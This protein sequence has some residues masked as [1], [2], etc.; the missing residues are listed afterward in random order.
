[1]NNLSL[2]RR[3]FNDD[4]AEMNRLMNRM[5]GE[6]GGL[7]TAG[8]TELATIDFTPTVDVEENDEGYVIKADLPQIK[9]EDVKINVQ[10]GILTLSGERKQEKEEKGKKFHRVERSYG[11]F[12]RSFQ[13]P[14]N[15]DDT[16]IAATYTDGVLKVLLPKAEQPKPN[17]REI[18]VG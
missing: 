15:V 16:K 2:F 11:S 12:F 10:N 3:S 17:A 4:L 8:K 1:M 5:F 6:T 13:L 18:T 7:T 9:R 14:D